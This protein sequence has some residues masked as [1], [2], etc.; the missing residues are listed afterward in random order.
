MTKIQWEFFCNVT[1]LFK[2]LRTGLVC[3]AE[4][5]Q[6]CKGPSLRLVTAG[7]SLPFLLHCELVKQL[8]HN[9]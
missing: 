5:P 2:T 4:T 1:P 7:F 9:T 6:N 3:V 8:S